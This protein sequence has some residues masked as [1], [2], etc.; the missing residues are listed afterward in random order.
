MLKFRNGF[1]ASP[2]R[3]VRHS[4]G[5]DALLDQRHRSQRRLGC[6]RLHSARASRPACSSSSRRKSSVNREVHAKFKFWSSKYQR[7]HQPGPFNPPLLPKL[8]NRNVGEPPT[9]PWFDNDIEHLLLLKFA[10]TYPH[11]PDCGKETMAS[12][13]VSRMIAAPFSIFREW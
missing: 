1:P 8:D 9:R 4:G 7:A 2:S 3:L 13:V 12:F 6:R 11:K 10:M 5:Q